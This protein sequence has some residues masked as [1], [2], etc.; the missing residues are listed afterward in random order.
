MSDGRPRRPLAPGVASAERGRRDRAVSS[1]VG[2]ALLLGVTVVSLGVLTA[3]IGA[4]VAD[5]ASSVAADRAAAALDATLGAEEAGSHAGTVHLADGRL[6]PLDRTVR[7]FDAGGETERIDVDGLEVHTGDRRVAFVSGG[8]AV[9]RPGNARLRAAPRVV[10]GDD[11]VLLSVTRVNVTAV[12]T[13]TA[14]GPAAVDL[15]ADVRHVRTTHD[16]GAYRLAVETATPGAW[17][18]RFADRSGVTV[19]DRTDADGD[20]VPSVVLGLPPDRTLHLVTYEVRVEVP[21]A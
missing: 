19:L 10:V 6:R 1:V 8:V 3:G 9:G 18:R 12:P 2:V 15:R 4:V 14:S 20:G 13:V 11:A 16:A 7:V 17:E 21:A 5:S